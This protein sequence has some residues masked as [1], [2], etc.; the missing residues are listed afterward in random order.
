MLT[1]SEAARLLA[2]ALG[3]DHHAVRHHRRINYHV[4]L[5]I[6]TSLRTGTRHDRLLR[7][8]FV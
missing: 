7:L 3:W 6:I 2:G 4:A 1:T 8:Q 5:F